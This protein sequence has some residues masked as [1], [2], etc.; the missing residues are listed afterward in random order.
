MA[1]TMHDEVQNICLWFDRHILVL[2][3]GNGEFTTASCLQGSSADVGNVS[4]LRWRAA[5]FQVTEWG[6]R[7]S[8]THSNLGSI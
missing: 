2:C 4:V 1:R 8:V 5:G 6:D 7:S 3:S